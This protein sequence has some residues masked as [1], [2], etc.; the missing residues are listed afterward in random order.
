MFLFFL[1]GVTAA[2]RPLTQSAPE[3]CSA[4]SLAIGKKSFHGI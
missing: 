2:L 4:P 1:A 3:T